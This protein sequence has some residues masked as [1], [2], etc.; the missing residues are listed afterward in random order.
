MREKINLYGH[1]NGLVTD[2]IKKIT[3]NTKNNFII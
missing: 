1:R 3:Y 2:I